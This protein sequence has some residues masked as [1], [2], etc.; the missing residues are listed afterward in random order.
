MPLGMEVELGPGDFVL[1]GDPTLS[2]KRGR[3]PSPIFGQFLL[4]PNGCIPLCTYDTGCK[5]AVYDIKSSRRQV[6]LVLDFYGRPIGQAIIFC[7]CGFFFFLAYSQQSQI[8]CLPYFSTWCDLSANLEGRSEMYCTWLAKNTGCKNSPSAH[9]RTALLSYIFATKACI[10][11][12]KKSLLNS[13][14][15]S[16]CLTIW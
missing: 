14:I 6:L 2:P 16:T 5:E 11:N 8:G 9:H 3:N 15:F 4:S 13:S 10:D 12:H 7:H 1:D